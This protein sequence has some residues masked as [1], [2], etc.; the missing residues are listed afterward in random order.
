MDDENYQPRA[1]CDPKLA[2]RT[3]SVS[4]ETSRERTQSFLARSVERL[5]IARD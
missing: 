2:M 3:E 5:F 1:L 4:S